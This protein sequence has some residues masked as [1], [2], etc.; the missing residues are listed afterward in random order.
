MDSWS[1]QEG[2]AFIS[3]GHESKHN[4]RRVIV[5]G[6]PQDV[7]KVGPEAWSTTLERLQVDMV[8]VWP[9]NNCLSD[10]W[11]PIK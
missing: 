10:I 3:S 1:Q 6:L 8:E 4:L 9:A 11:L 7:K 5:E 2:Q